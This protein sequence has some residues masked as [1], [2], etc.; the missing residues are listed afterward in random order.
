MKVNIGRYRKSSGRK[1]QVRIDHSDTWSMD[2]TLAHIILPMLIHLRDTKHGVPHE[3]AVVGGEDYD[4]QLS[5]DFYTETNS[6]CFDIKSAQ[7]DD[8]LNKMIWSFEQLVRD[9]HEQLYHHGDRGDMIWT[10]A[11]T[12]YNPIT[13]KDEEVSSL[14]FSNPSGSYWDQEGHLL[15]QD[16]IQEGLD[17]FAKYYQNLWD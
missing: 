10:P 13:K 14:T 17:L 1:I 16:R 8:C 9:E 3:F 12:S 11:G 2:H 4:D 5:F 7:W 15:H 6:Q